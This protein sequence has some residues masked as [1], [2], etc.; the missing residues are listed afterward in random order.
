[1][2]REAVPPTTL[3]PAAPVDGAVMLSRARAEVHSSKGGRH[4][5]LTPQVHAGI[6]A[7]VRVGQYQWV[8]AAAEGIP[9]STYAK[10]RVRGQQEWE[11]YQAQTEA[12]HEQPHA[13]DAECPVLPSIF[14]ALWYDTERASA[15]AR[16][17]AEARV[18]AE[19]PLAYLMKGPGRA[20]P[21]REGWS[22][23]VEVAANVQ[24]TAAPALDL[25]KLTDA[26]LAALEEMYAVAGQGTA[27]V[28]PR[29]G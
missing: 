15:Q 27:A 12:W 23:R 22:D 26:Q 4:T 25:S 11:E 8:A 7:R 9:Y 18:M 29:Q 20:K 24:T 13:A 28:A 1:M 16:G 19:N 2:D 5:L 3:I 10:W 14:A 17:G 6:V 21:D